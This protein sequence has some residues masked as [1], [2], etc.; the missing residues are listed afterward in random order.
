MP[1]GQKCALLHCFLLM[2]GCKLRTPAACQ[3][4]GS[5]SHSCVPPVQGCSGTS[6]AAACRLQ[7]GARL[8]VQSRKILQ[9]TRQALLVHLQCVAGHRCSA[10]Q[11]Q[12]ALVLT[13]LRPAVQSRNEM[14]CIRTF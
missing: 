13:D 14:L 7:T 2:T 12:R 11:A 6:F 5:S 1:E 4:C 9:S 10:A 8:V 3:K